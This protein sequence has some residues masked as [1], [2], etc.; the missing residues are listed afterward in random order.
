M[1]IIVKEK[2]KS[3]NCLIIKTTP[4]AGVKEAT[5][6]IEC[7]E[8]NIIKIPFTLYVNDLEDLIEKK[9][10]EEFSFENLTDFSKESINEWMTNKGIY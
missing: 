10:Y 2:E 3:P 6:I 9:N 7:E 4:F 5:G 8:G 1:K